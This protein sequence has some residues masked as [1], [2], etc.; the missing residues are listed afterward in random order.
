MWPGLRILGAL[1][2]GVSKGRLILCIRQVSSGAGQLEGLHIVLR[3]DAIW[4][5]AKKAIA[6]VNVKTDAHGADIL[7]SIK[8]YCLCHVS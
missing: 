7:K 4:Q 6:D 5:L 3:A 2:I 8:G 1:Q